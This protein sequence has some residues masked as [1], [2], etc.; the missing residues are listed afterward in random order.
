[1]NWALIFTLVA[2]ITAW[3]LQNGEIGISGSGDV[4]ERVP[5]SGSHN[6]VLTSGR[7]LDITFDIL[8]SPPKPHQVMALLRSEKGSS[9]F[10][11]K[12]R[13]GTAKIVIPYKSLPVELTGGKVKIDVLLSSL[14]GQSNREPV[15]TMKVQEKDTHIP[16]ESLPGKFTGVFYPL[17]EILHQYKPSPARVSAPIAVFGAVVILVLLVALIRGWQMFMGVP[18]LVPS[19]LPFIASLGGIE[20]VFIGYYL[21]N[22][23]FVTLAYIACLTPVAF[24]TGI[25]VFRREK[26]MRLS[27]ISKK[28]KLT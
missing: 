13:A 19:T 11:A 6:L 18:C 24:L 16:H 10:P 7:S 14:D 3:S 8:G 5:F 27:D 20:L 28:K 12:L 15:G 1:M 9:L 22:S 2:P 4:G 17:P 21:G 26:R 23:I 25:Y